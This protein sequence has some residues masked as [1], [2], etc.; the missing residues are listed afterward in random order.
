MLAPGG[1]PKGLPYPDQGPFLETRK[2]RTCPSRGPVW[3]R[4]LRKTKP[5]PFPPSIRAALEPH[6]LKRRASNQEEKHPKAAVNS[7]AAVIE[8]EPVS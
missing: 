4:P 6:Q 5:V 2:G 8:R 7:A 1:S 3:D